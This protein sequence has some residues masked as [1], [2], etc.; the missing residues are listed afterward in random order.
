MVNTEISTIWSYLL[1]YDETGK[2]SY[3]STA[4]TLF[5]GL[6]EKVEVPEE[7]EAIGYTLQEFGPYHELGPGVRVLQSVINY[8]NVEGVVEGWISALLSSSNK[9]N[10]LLLE[11]AKATL[12]RLLV[13]FGMVINPLRETELENVFEGEG[14]KEG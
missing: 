10:P 14:V 13:A 3:L 4:W 11:V 9:P 2:P 6:I 12:V 7:F 5:A 1:R 8:E